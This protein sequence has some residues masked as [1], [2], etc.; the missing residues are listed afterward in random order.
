[1]NN[2][3]VSPNSVLIECVIVPSTGGTTNKNPF[4]T[5]KQL[6]NKKVVAIESFSNQDVVNSPISQANPCIN[7]QVFN[8][9]FLTLYRASTPATGNSPAQNEG[10][11]YDQ[12]PFSVL[13][14]VVNQNNVGV[15]LTSSC[16]D[17]FRINPTE[18]SWTKCYVTCTPSVPI[19]SAV[20]ALFLVHYLNE[21]Q[22]WKPYAA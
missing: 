10:L 19:S 20:S 2:F 1:M 9:S 8:T 4:G 16:M 3:W 14:R 17:L 7:A 13:R 11:Y 21:Y 5:Q 12:L 15:N 6:Q 22:D 18:M